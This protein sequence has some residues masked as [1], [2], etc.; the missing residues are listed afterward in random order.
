[1]NVVLSARR[2]DRLEA[3]SKE[4]ERDFEVK[5]QIA[6]ADLAEPDG[7][8]KLLAAVSNVEIGLL[9]NNAGLGY[10]GRFDLL[11]GERLRQLVTVNCE[12][13]LVLTHALVRG[14]RERG[15]GGVIFTGSVAGRQPLPLHE[16]AALGLRSLG[17]QPSVIAGWR[18]WIRA[19]LVSRGLT[20][21]IAVLGA[22]AY[23]SKQTREH[24][25]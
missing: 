21:P 1:M 17:Q 4:I 16:V 5:T 22:N 19:N 23:M 10:A 9:V 24:L 6:V 15:R 8:A 18:N 13:P 25:R 3:L 14:M 7:A 2:E 11:D 20:R 12:A